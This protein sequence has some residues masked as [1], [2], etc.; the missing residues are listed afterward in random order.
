MKKHALT[1]QDDLHQLGCDHLLI[2]FRFENPHS[3]LTLEAGRT[4]RIWYRLQLYQ[5]G[6]LDLYRTKLGYISDFKLIRYS[7]N[8]F[9]FI[10]L[11][12]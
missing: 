9:S 2:R 7:V 10:S 4:V 3:Q 8:C 1:I 11:T 12:R 5:I 6:Y